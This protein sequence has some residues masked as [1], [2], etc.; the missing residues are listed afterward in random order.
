[1]PQPDNILLLTQ[2]GVL[3]AKSVRGYDP[4]CRGFLKK[5]TMLGEAIS[6]MINQMM[7]PWAV[8]LLRSISFDDILTELRSGPLE[9]DQMA[10]CFNW[11]LSKDV[12]RS[13]DNRKQFVN[14]ARFKHGA[15]VIALDHIKSILDVQT[16]PSILPQSPLPASTLPYQIS[17]AVHRTSDLKL[18]LG[19]ADLSVSQWLQ[20]TYTPSTDDNTLFQNILI[21]LAQ[22]WQDLGKEQE[23]IKQT[24]GATSCIP[25]PKGIYLPGNAY[26]SPKMASVFPNLPVINLADWE[27]ASS[28]LEAEVTNFVSFNAVSFNFRS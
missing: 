18:L 8:D 6:N 19:T 20:H 12:I 27:A 24:L 13:E 17:G 3:P 5:L 21:S 22:H 16:A 1:M 23:K 26:V 15:R 7:G 2:H 28:S 14:A 4:G 11:V 25:T 10:A 9:E